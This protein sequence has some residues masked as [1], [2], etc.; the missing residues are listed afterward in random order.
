MKTEKKFSQ[1]TIKFFYRN[2]DL[3]TERVLWYLS[4]LHKKVWNHMLNMCKGNFEHID[5]LLD[6]VNPK[7]QE[8]IQKLKDFALENQNEEKP[9][10]GKTRTLSEFGMLYC[11]GPIRNNDP[12]LLQLPLNDLQKPCRVLSKSWKSFFELKRRGDERARPPRYQNEQNFFTLQWEKPTI[13]T[14]EIEGIIISS[15]L[16]FNHKIKGV[17]E[18]H[19]ELPHY[20]SRLIADKKVRF[21][22]IKRTQYH[23]NRTSDFEINL[24]YEVPKTEKEEIN[25]NMKIA[26]VDV[27]SRNIAL[28]VSGEQSSVKTWNL[29]KWDQYFTKQRSNIEARMKTKTKGSRAWRDL[30][31]ARTKL[32]KKWG[33]KQKDLHRKI[34]HEMIEKADVFYIGITNVRLGL[35]KSENGSKSQHRAVQNTGNLSRFIRFLEEKAEEYGKHVIKVPDQK[36]ETTNNQRKVLGAVR[37]YEYGIK[38]HAQVL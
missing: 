30:F 27:G 22:T 20:V 35:A 34:A 28:V 38:N 14:K 36:V 8:E 19:I 15:F 21:V 9:E 25:S 10:Y 11:L 13:I 24:V 6:K 12:E 7:G 18:I 31:D 5:S 2:P 17:G 26:G 1:K 29:P 23:V 4:S 3:H 37:N 33:D 32:S 16:V